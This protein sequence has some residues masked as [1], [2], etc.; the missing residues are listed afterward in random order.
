MAIGVTLLCSAWAGATSGAAGWSVQRTPNSERLNNLLF[1]VSCASVRSCVAAGESYEVSNTRYF[2]LAELWRARRWTIQRVPMPAGM[3]HSQLNSVSCVSDG[4]CVAVGDSYT[5]SGREMTLAERWSGRRWTIEPTPPTRFKASELLAISCWAARG[6]MAVG[7][8][9]SPAVGG[10]GALLAE[11]WNGR[12]WN[13][14]RTPSPAATGIDSLQGVSC[15]SA[16]ACTAVGSYGALRWDG[17]RWTSQRIP[18]PPYGEAREL[19]GISCTTARDCT[20]VGDYMP[21]SYVTKA[22]A[23]RWNGRKWVIQHPPTHDDSILENVS[24]TAANSCT[25]VDDASPLIERW[26]GVKWEAQR[27]TIPVAA[28]Y[29][30]EAGLAGVSCPSRGKCTAVGDYLNHAGNARTLAEHWNGP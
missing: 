24:C 26:N 21:T 8:S 10:G 30:G 14:R 11:Q 18:K 27:T 23:E 17:R 9:F 19:V 20:G 28:R 7:D 6:C 3:V 22:L 29:R 13:I 5:H 15:V 12:A 16:R 2:A 1:A 25:A 4:D